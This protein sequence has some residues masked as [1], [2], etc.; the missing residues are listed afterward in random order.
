MGL[1]FTTDEIVRQT[2]DIKG[3][4]KMK[5]IEAEKAKILQVFKIGTATIYCKPDKI[6][7]YKKYFN[8]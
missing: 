1:Q 4:A 2:N 7:D 5:Q 3:L 6:D 8:Q